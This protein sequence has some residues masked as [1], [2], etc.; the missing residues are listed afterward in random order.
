MLFEVTPKNSYQDGTVF[1]VNAKSERRET[2]AFLHILPKTNSLV[3]ILL[4]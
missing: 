1:L 4:F 2:Q 3:K